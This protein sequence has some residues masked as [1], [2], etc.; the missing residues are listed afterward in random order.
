MR[1][2]SELMAHAPAPTLSNDLRFL[3]AVITITEAALSRPRV[4]LLIFAFGL[5]V[6]SNIKV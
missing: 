5:K 1:H 2:W 3:L 4:L 6:P